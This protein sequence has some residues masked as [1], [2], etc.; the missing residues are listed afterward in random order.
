MMK[1]CS[2]R[3]RGPWVWC[4]FDTSH[5]WRA[6]GKKEIIEEKTDNKEKC[7]IPTRTNASATCL[8]GGVR[9]RCMKMSEC[10]DRPEQ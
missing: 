4:G 5:F 2:L 3:R 1:A 6:V 8:A 7:E 10:D 9:R